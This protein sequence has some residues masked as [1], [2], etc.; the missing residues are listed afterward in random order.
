MSLGMTSSFG[1]SISRAL[2][3]LLLLCLQDLAHGACNICF[4]QGSG[5]TG[6][7]TTCPWV[8]TVAANTAA[9]AA[10]AGAVASISTLLPAKFV[11]LFPKSALQALAS[12]AIKVESGSAP[13]NPSGKSEAEIFSAIMAG[14]LTKGEATI[15]FNGRIQTAKD[16]LEVEK[17]KASIRSLAELDK[18]G[19]KDSGCMEGGF[20]YVLFT[21]SKVFCAK[22]HGAGSTSFEFCGEC[23]DEP[24]QK[25]ASKSFTS[26]LTRPKDV[27]GLYSLLNGFT[28]TCHALG[29]AN[30]L[31]MGPFLE[32]VVFEP[33]RCGAVSWPVA[34]EC[35]IIYLRMV[36]DGS[37]KFKITSV[38][39]EAG[40]MDSVRA[41]AM[42]SAHENF[43]SEIFRSLGGNPIKPKSEKDPLFKG[44]GEYAGKIKGSISGA[45]RGCTAWNNGSAHLSKNVDP[46]SGKCRFLHKCDQ[47][48]DDKGVYGQC[49]GDHMRKECDYDVAHKVKVPVK[50]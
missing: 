22:V 16:M 17:A 41:Q 15:E 43:S 6:D 38:V 14:R 18:T 42:V 12:L 1:I 32:N 45:T 29:L 50:A 19:V 20:L 2:L 9:A 21:E 13:F 34:F 3:L 10:A 28:L 47:F 44:E 27:H 7:P 4:G 36:E 30:V 11:R 35:L 37:G 40:G 49:L 24:S 33:I 26:S 23:D 46:K 39:H 31:A 48:V 25:P 8:V 5:C